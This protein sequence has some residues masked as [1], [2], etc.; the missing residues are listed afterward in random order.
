MNVEIETEA[1][2]FHSWEYI[3]RNSI[4]VWSSPVTM[5]DTIYMKHCTCMDSAL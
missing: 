2:Q 5:K 1:A 3:N 4:A